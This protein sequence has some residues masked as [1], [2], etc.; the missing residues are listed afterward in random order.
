MTLYELY[1]A[2][3]KQVQAGTVEL[4]PGIFAAG[5]IAEFYLPLLA[6]KSLQIDDAALDPPTA[7]PS[8]S[9]FVLKGRSSSLGMAD[10]APLDAAI[11]FTEEM[12]AIQS[13]ADYR[14]ARPWTLL[15]IEW[16]GLSNPGFEISVGN[17][18]VPAFGILGGRLSCLERLSVGLQLP[19]QGSNWAFSGQLQ[20]PAG[21][22]D[23]I[24]LA[25]GINLANVLPP[26]LDAISA[27]GVSA[28]ALSYDPKRAVLDSLSFTVTQNEPDQLFTLFPFLPG[29]PQV[30][31]LV[32]N[33][34]VLDP[35]RQRKVLFDFSGQ[36]VFPSAAGAEA[37]RPTLMLTGSLPNFQIRGA[38]LDNG[39]VLGV[40]DIL[41]IILPPSIKTGIKGGF[42]SLTFLADTANSNYS[43]A[44]TFEAEWDITVA[45]PL[46]TVPL[47]I[48][49]LS[50]SLQRSGRSNGATFGGV[51]QVGQDGAPDSFQLS[52]MASSPVGS[53]EWTYRGWLSSGSISLSAL[54]YTFTNG[55]FKIPSDQ[56]DLVIDAL[57]VEISSG[58]TYSFEVGASMT[59]PLGIGTVKG[60]LG[61][62]SNGIIPAGAG[63]RRSQRLARRS[64]L[65]VRRGALLVHAAA[66]ADKP[67][68][69]YRMMASYTLLNIDW[70]LTVDLRD[71][72][73]YR[74]YLSL[75]DYLTGEYKQ[76]PKTKETT[77]TI[78]FGDVSLGDIVA[79]LLSW[80]MPGGPRALSA[81]WNLLDNIPLNRLALVVNITKKK[82]SISY[83]ANGK[84]GLN[85]GIFTLDGISLTYQPKPGAA[86]RYEVIVE[87]DGKF[88]TGA[89][90]PS[91]DAT[92]PQSAPVPAGSGNKYLDI[93]LLALGQHVTISGYESFD[94]VQAAIDAMRAL[95]APQGGGIPVAAN[96]PKGQPMFNPKSNWLVAMN[97]G[98][99][100]FGGDDHNALQGGAGAAKAGY[101]LDLSIIFND[102][103]LYALRFA[104]DGPAAKVLAGL[105]F[106]IM[107]KKVSDSIG[108]YQ[109][110]LALPNAVRQLQFGA[111][112][113]TLPNF[114]VQI[115]TNGDFLVD[116]GFPYNN[117]FSVSFAIQIQ[118]G[119]LPLLGAG[120][121][122]FGK[123]SSAT[124][125]VVPSTRN[126]VFNPVI[127][128]GIGL[129]VGLGKDINIGIMQAGFS[130]TVFGIIEGVYA[131]YN[132]F[133]GG[134]SSDFFLVKGTLGLIG[135]LY[136]TVS[137][138]I[139]SADFEIV[140]RVYVQASYQ[141][142]GALPLTIAAS[143]DI[144]LTVKI[145]LGFF[146]IRIHLSFSATV[147]ETLVI[148][149]DRSA[150]APWNRAGS[151]RPAVLEGRRNLHALRAAYQP[152]RRRRLVM[153]TLKHAAE[154]DKPPLTLYYGPAQAVAAKSTRGALAEQTS[155]IVHL[156]YI[157]T[158]NDSFTNLCLE[159]FNWL[160]TSYR[161]G[162]ASRAALQ[163]AVIS[164]PELLDIYHELTDPGIV[165]PLSVKQIDQFLNDH[166]AVSIAAADPGLKTEKSVAIFPMP[167]EVV[168]TAPGSKPR[169]LSSFTSCSEQ[170]VRTVSDYFRDLQMQVESDLAAAQ[171]A[172]RRL[173]PE[174]EQSF[175]QSVAALVFQDFFVMLASQLVQYGLDA[176]THYKYALNRHAN[177]LSGIVA[178]ANG[179][180][181]PSG[182]DENRLNAGVLAEANRDAPLAGGLRLTVSGCTIQAASGMSLQ[183]IVDRY[184]SG[185]SA[186]GL[187]EKNGAVQYLINGGVT[188]TNSDGDKILTQSDSTFAS[189]QAQ[190]GWP[191]AQFAA[192]A[193]GL[194][195]LLNNR[196]VMALPDL[197]Y[198][199]AAG[200]TDTLALIANRYA[201]TPA[202][203]ANAPA[204]Q[205]LAPFFHSSE[206]EPRYLDLPHLYCLTVG[207]TIEE[208]KDCNSLQQLAG[209]VSRFLVYGMRLPVGAGTGLSFNDP[210][211][212]PCAGKD[213]SMYSVA[214]QQFELPAL[215]PTDTVVASMAAAPQAPAWLRFAQGSGASVTFSADMVKT[216]NTVLDEARGKGV[217]APIDRLGIAAMRGDQPLQYDF[218]QMI[219]WQADGA[220]A[221]S[222]GAPDPQEKAPAPYIW[223][224]SRSLLAYLAST[225]AGRPNPKVALEIGTI[226]PATGQRQ[227]A[228]CRYYG[229]GSLLNFSI[230]KVASGGNA[231]TYELVGADEH[232]VMVLE[233]L[234]AASTPQAMPVAG[235]TLLFA[236]NA[237]SNRDAGLVSAVAAETAYF[238]TQA[239]LS[240]YT[241]PAG[242]ASSARNAAA[243]APQGLLGNVYDFLKLLWECSITRSGGYYLYYEDIA[244]QSGLSDLLFDANGDATLRLLLTYVKSGAGVEEDRLYDFMNV[245]VTGQNI[246]PAA[247]FLFGEAAPFAQTVA[248]GQHETL[249]AIAARL[250]LPAG[251]AAEALGGAALA[252]NAT[253]LLN[254]LIYQAGAAA[255]GQDAASIAN[256]YMLTPAQLEAAN[257]GRGLDFS[258]PIPVW[259]ALR[260]PPLSYPV[261]SAK[262]GNTLASVAAYF[263]AA[264]PRLAADNAL[265][266]GLFLPTQTTLNLAF[267]NISTTTPPGCLALALLRPNPGPVPDPGQPG[268][269]A[270]YL[271]HAY[272]LLSY[273]FVAADLHNSD[274]PAT[275]WGIPVGP[276]TESALPAHEKIRAIP[277]EDDVS[278]WEYHKSLPAYRVLNGPP[279]AGADG[280]PPV[281]GDP[282]SVLNRIAQVEFAW[283]DL[284]GNETITALSDPILFPHGPQNAPPALLGYTDALIPLS[285]WPSMMPQY[286]FVAGADSPAL[287][288]V[289]CFDTSPYT[290]D[291][292]QPDKQWREQAGKDLERYKSVYYQLC[293]PSL[294]GR[295]EFAVRF[296]IQTTLLAADPGYLAPDQVEVI[297]QAVKTIVLYL[298]ARAAGQEYTPPAGATCQ[299]VAQT[300]GGADTDWNRWCL[301]TPL[302]AARQNQDELF[303]LKVEFA[304]ARNRAFVAPDFADDRAIYL[305]ATTV[306]PYVARQQD[307]GRKN[308][309]DTYALDAFAAEFERIF[310]VAG[311]YC[312]KLASGY[313]RFSSGAGAGEARKP[314]WVVR[315]AF[316][317][318]SGIYFGKE[319][320]ARFF[321]PTPLATSLQS[322]TVAIHP[323]DA[324]LGQPDPD[325]TYQ[326]T[327]QNIDM[328]VWMAS[329]FAAI[330][331]LLSPDLISQA[332]LVDYLSGS[333]VLPGI[334]KAK[335]DLATAY[336]TTRTA[337]VLAAQQ[338]ADPAS[339]AERLRQ[340][341][342]IRLSEAYKV[343]AIVCYPMRVKGAFHGA[344]AG[345][346]PRL[347]GTP[348]IAAAA[349]G[350]GK[351]DENY[352][353]SS[354]KLSLDASGSQDL[355]FL[356]Y[357]K[358]PD[359]R[360]VAD[361]EIDYAVTNLEHD[362][363]PVSGIKDYEA[364][365][366]L[367]F[368]QPPRAGAVDNP[369]YAKLGTVSI[370]VPLR[371]Y[372]PAPSMTS[373]SQ[374]Q[375]LPAEPTLAQI[376]RW[377]YLYGYTGT[378][379]QQ[380]TVHTIVRMNVAA[381]PHKGFAVDDSKKL[382]QVLA[383]FTTVQNELNDSFINSLRR[384]TRQMKGGDD[385][386]LRAKRGLEALLALMKDAATY[387]PKWIPTGG[388]NIDEA[389]N[390]YLIT[391][392]A[393]PGYPSRFLLT[394]K[395]D[396]AHRVV[397]PDLPAPLPVLD[398]YA[399]VPAEQ[400]HSFWFTQQVNG[401]TVYL[402]PA[403][404]RAIT[405]RQIAIANLN[406]FEYQN[407][408]SAAYV[409]RNEFFGGQAAAE[410][411]VYTSQLAKFANLLAP[412][413]DNASAIAV[414]DPERAVP[415]PEPLAL[416][417][418]LQRFLAD[419]FA[420]ANGAGQKITLEAS[421]SYPLVQG[422]QADQRIMVTQP[423]LLK[424]YAPVDTS[425]QGV[426]DFAAGLARALSY[427]FQD[428]M[429]NYDPDGSGARR[430]GFGFDL[431]L[432]A[433]I[434]DPDTRMPLL[435]LRNLS[436][437]LD[438]L[439][440]VP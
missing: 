7:D 347:Y 236:P 127:V 162:A 55:V 404:A 278:D 267:T 172:A 291:A 181:P 408:W 74:Y 211:D 51:L 435:R 132:P 370:P 141:S 350:S 290:A 415:A 195:D 215:K 24:Q 144:R 29:F 86:S 410:R 391:Q 170:Y 213:C 131:A 396:D 440:V 317:D 96:P 225:S 192:A 108:M 8:L 315:I 295:G 75:S 34:T 252:P 246:D 70:T 422:S 6:A 363:G 164:Y 248:I 187:I 378:G 275:N 268:Y 81:P 32:F 133:D 11:V 180:R 56:F 63:I 239:N 301:A 17:G 384:V 168:L 137:F 304:I 31:A 224:F 210:S 92:D 229:W 289:L 426:A 22:A 85:F 78:S 94:S 140:V 128:L 171:S 100:R 439:T 389:G 208:I 349:N 382:F 84:L 216:L 286:L 332:F 233:R 325:R 293:Q 398:G 242:R 308:G 58:G 432:F 115:F 380:D 33:F 82:I 41:H 250:N 281:A 169:T 177:S 152:Q 381:P 97:F 255:P 376:L 64:A 353:F 71:K 423:V 212:Q 165:T 257:Q 341:L 166:V 235:L 179:M 403:A 226:H 338:G 67:Q 117:D 153:H 43:F 130:L 68:P 356:F 361:F 39:A 272:N 49:E 421:Y 143:V 161:P 66:A 358:R 47:V 90:I 188:I 95:E 412:L 393:D 21:L 27:I 256:Y 287:V 364:S 12:G 337:P 201:I 266:P 1:Q 150:D 437:P 205:E 80:A 430:G 59:L 321:A 249:E 428:Q 26:P 38:L 79:L 270:A 232:G 274:F 54:L 296:A 35:V 318:A 416:E 214:G 52:V 312:L 434:G 400:A 156:L 37:P 23:V 431:S 40:D 283:R 262:A 13:L 306:D 219:P 433:T 305:A 375:V 351:A 386:V 346:A 253:L 107:Y 65:P 123:L 190:A 149:E 5:G 417:P 282:Y 19:L 120:G 44:G 87:I 73:D 103:N 357:A 429:P 207:A 271:Q 138:A 388:A 323:W 374:R 320:E 413:I 240:T 218:A 319:G 330:D 15:G 148:G 10:G 113:V 420:A 25:G 359:D 277:A 200:H 326:A 406:L 313:D 57:N 244:A 307:P 297:L 366:W 425:A 109:A 399:T 14:T 83:P 146:S 129:Q 104:L 209:M 273:R 114:G 193:A 197:S 372:P 238:I 154:G 340:Q 329:F 298:Q 302:P 331:Q 368:L 48:K 436:L 42:R 126:G 334:L 125:S 237:S 159:M 221:L 260:I 222:Y 438:G 142:Y 139:I 300:L 379:M 182:A 135:R 91:W 61:V 407:A 411:F 259:T 387:L 88:V 234:L 136:G 110:K 198:T 367:S 292:S 46:F 223:P 365:S 119:P 178:W 265:T 247:D 76:D 155:R 176:M 418:T 69:A 45:T 53:T 30:G 276:T 60:F 328:D 288:L 36:V 402:D 352:S 383:Q 427:W 174:A 322:E 167:P 184:G 206:A 160:V 309:S 122:Y 98:V 199:T 204:N 261:A 72:D 186:Q 269:A 394:L 175:S 254:D 105:A 344:D 263:G 333:A 194:T 343:T 279:A 102:P 284:Y 251:Q 360:A 3:S 373:Q 245:A 124:T 401:D 121:V 419:L 314:L 147:R 191:S 414:C 377:D 183:S 299:G 93:R 424:P 354:A 77:V 50:M 345:I 230:K 369:L 134:D 348:Q 385:T 316:S 335:N 310:T 116:I 173:Q 342:L 336:A 158:A 111:C 405:A 390:Y 241:N 228:P 280:L 118:A 362:I 285:A 112:G 303:A 18:T 220:V 203:L 409:K 196:T 327:F 189:L 217:Q 62:Y 99:L 227:A 258:Q 294:A 395:P 371:A 2:I 101:L 311:G 231:F 243:P 16:F 324:T 145:S 392:G 28:V 185:L 339:A 397:Y 151:G 4:V 9:R 157:D 106:E 355:S 202:A 20:P 89:G 163:D 264:L